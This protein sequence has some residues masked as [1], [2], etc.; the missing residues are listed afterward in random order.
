MLCNVLGGQK[1]TSA[2]LVGPT[3]FPSSHFF[4]AVVFGSFALVFFRGLES[5]SNGGV[6]RLDLGNAVI[7]VARRPTSA[8]RWCGGCTAILGGAVVCLSDF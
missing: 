8:Q 5:R 1:V 6:M 7:E 4:P 3:I 2:N